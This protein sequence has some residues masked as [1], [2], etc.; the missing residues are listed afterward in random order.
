M[1]K[2]S[3]SLIIVAAL[4]LT[5]CTTI[6]DMYTD[7]PKEVATA[8]ASLAS[9]E[10]LALIYA[11]MP[12]CGQSSAVLCHNQN[13]IEDIKTADNVAANAIAAADTAQT[14]DAVN[15]AMTALKALT[16]ITNNLPV[17]SQ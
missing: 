3:V 4:A 6:Q 10:R 13:I 8:Q 2:K 7:I 1:L 15:A 17:G 14:Q 11:A 5:S 16:D 9:A 12:L